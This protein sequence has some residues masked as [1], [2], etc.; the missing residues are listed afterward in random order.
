MREITQCPV[1]KDD[2]LEA[3]RQY[4]FR[5]P[6]QEGRRKIP[7]RIRE[8]IRIY[9]DEIDGGS[10]NEAKVTISRCRSCSFLFTNPRLTTEDLERKYAAIAALDLAHR[11]RRGR[12]PHLDER[13]R[14]TTP[15]LL[16]HL[17]KSDGRILDYG[18][19]EGFLLSPLIDAGHQGYVVDYIDYPREDERIAY[20]GTHLG[21]TVAENGPYD[22]VLLLHT[23][24][25]VADPVAMVGSLRELLAPEG[26]LYVE[27]PLGAWLEWESL[28]EPLTHINFFSEQSLVRT[29]SEAGLHPHYLSTSWQYVTH[30]EKTPC[31][32]LVVGREP[33]N[34]FRA[35][36]VRTGWQQMRPWHQLLSALTVNP[37]YY[38][39]TA[40]KALLP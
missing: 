34:T 12:P 15:L 16:Q 26:L 13:R 3:E 28:K 33:K 10:S 36:N 21:E 2:H 19:A 7:T 38:G 4:V 11:R 6:V 18:G 30:P 39:K 27:V 17:P 37:A 22:L 1:C 9:I 8:L 14:R 25:H 29:I 35:D 24:E 20:L 40:L 5:L 31:I 32:N 23:L